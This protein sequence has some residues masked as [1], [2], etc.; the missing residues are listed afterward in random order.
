MKTVI[1]AAG[2]KIDF[3]AYAHTMDDTLREWLH[4]EMAPCSDQAFYD[5]AEGFVQKHSDVRSLIKTDDGADGDG[6]E[7][8]VWDWMIE[9]L[10]GG[11]TGTATAAEIAAEWDSLSDG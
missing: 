7:T 1:S 4:A 8:T 11:S 3:D 6:S 9:G 2:K 5:A 10:R